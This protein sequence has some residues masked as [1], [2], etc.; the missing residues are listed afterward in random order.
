VNS[1]GSGDTQLTTPAPNVL[2]TPTWSP[3]GLRVAFV[4]WIGADTQIWIMD[5]D[6]S[7]LTQVT[8]VPGYKLNLS[9]S[10]RGDR[11]AFDDLVQIYTI[12]PD[13]S[14]QQTL[15]TP[16][17][18]PQYAATYP[19]WSPDGSRMVYEVFYECDGD[20][21][22]DIVTKNLEGPGETLVISDGSGFGGFDRPSWSPDGTRIVSSGFTIAPDG[23]GYATGSGGNSLDWQPL[24]VDIP[25]TYARPAGASPLRISLVPAAQECTAPNR[26]HGPPLAFGSCAPPQPGSSNLTVGVGDGSPA[27][28][29]SIG[30]VRMVVHPGTPGGVDDTDVAIRFSLSNVMKASD[31][32]EYTGEL[33]ASAQVRLTDKQGTVS[34][35]TQ[36]F[37][38]EFDVPCVGTASTVDKSLCEL[39]TTL[40]AVRP[41]A[42]AE[43]T[44]AVWALDQVRVH[45]GGS[46]EDADTTADNS[47]FAVQGVFVP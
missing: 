17:G 33:R 44:R 13:G 7:D 16:A 35:T 47:L 20:T 23:T 31:L 41:G 15:I 19:D 3:D 43:G 32:S 29:R 5:A 22:G 26:T 25:S 36:D 2:E 14:D 6:G 38:L 10:P 42:A 34:S 24:P 39:T 9:W 1:D 30:F 12:R 8:N 45:D 27:Y 37:P 46:D 40:D 4:R 18:Q 28:S 21:C 11:I